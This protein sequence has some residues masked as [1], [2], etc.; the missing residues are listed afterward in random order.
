MDTGW[1]QMGYCRGVIETIFNKSAIYAGNKSKTKQKKTISERYKE[2]LSWVF[3]QTE[4]H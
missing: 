3:Q 2:F 1:G 4:H